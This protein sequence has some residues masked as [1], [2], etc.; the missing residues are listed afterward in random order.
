MPSAKMVETRF[1]FT[2]LLAA[3]VKHHHRREDV[4][5]LFE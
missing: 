3:F 5:K 1:V 2:N 4:V